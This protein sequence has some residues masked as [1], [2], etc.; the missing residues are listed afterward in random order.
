VSKIKLL[1]LY[2]F[3]E[4]FFSPQ[5]NCILRNWRS[6]LIEDIGRAT[7]SPARDAGG[8]GGIH[9]GASSPGIVGYETGKLNL[10]SQVVFTAEKKETLL[11]PF[12]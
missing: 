4:V 2:V 12:F 5:P 6:W 9:R 11:I 8:G 1:L 3:E 7:L 10:S